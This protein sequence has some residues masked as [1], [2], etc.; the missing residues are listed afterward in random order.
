MQ[1]LKE[2]FREI[3]K[4]FSFIE[5]KLIG[6]LQYNDTKKGTKELDVLYERFQTLCGEIEKC[7]KEHESKKKEERIKINRGNRKLIADQR[8]STK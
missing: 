5:I 2:Y 8:K 1:F 6:R 4:V 3:R 7:I